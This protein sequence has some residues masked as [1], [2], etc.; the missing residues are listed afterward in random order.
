M[1]KSIFLFLAA[2]T[3][4]TA[5]FS[6]SEKYIAA[7]QKN[8][9][10]FDS[11]KTAE[12]YTKMANTFERIGDA[13]KT[14]W[15]PYYY[16]ALSLSSSGWLPQVAD[17]DANAEKMLALCTKAETLAPDN[18]AKSEIETVRNMAATQQMMVNPQT[19]WATY[20]KAA[21]EA[22]QKAMALN[23]N[24]PRVYYLQGMSMMGTPVQFGGGKDKAIPLFEKA[25]EL[26]KATKPATLY[27]GW[28]H[29]QAE[30]ALAQCKQ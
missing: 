16:A 27:P 20:G 2:F 8:L 25:I 7:M 28:G 17:K 11:A 13:E 18:I 22:L 19:R 15:S 12:D 29:K 26:Y 30:E 24:N 3:F 4:T 14:Q 1:K 21:G 9:Q 23:A 10:L 6:Q 5:A